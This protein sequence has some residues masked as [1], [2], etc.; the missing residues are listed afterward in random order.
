MSFVVRTSDSAKLQS[1]IVTIPP[2]STHLEEY[3]LIQAILKKDFETLM[4]E[5]NDFED[6]RLF[7][8]NLE[9]C[10]I[11][12]DV[13]LD[14]VSTG[15]WLSFFCTHDTGDMLHPYF[16]FFHEDAPR[17]VF[18]GKIPKGKILS[19]KPQEDE[20]ILAIENLSEMTW[21]AENEWIGFSNE[22]VLMFAEDGQ[23]EIDQGEVAI[24][25]VANTDDVALIQNVTHG[26]YLEV[27]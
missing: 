13:M 2:K 7:F 25:I 8:D 21:N 23:N 15:F 14:Q 5:F 20:Q 3:L 11:V 16:G 17:K 18:W 4:R 9:S 10:E 27:E 1:S 24:V 6:V 19:S 12:Q 26:F 22:E